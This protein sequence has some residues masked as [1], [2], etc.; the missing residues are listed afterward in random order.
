M[1]IAEFHAM[2]DEDHLPRTP[3]L[4]VDV[5]DAARTRDRVAGAD[6]RVCL[7]ALARIEAAAARDAR[8]VLGQDATPRELRSEPSTRIEP[9]TI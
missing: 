3:R 6:W 2:H 8:E 7:Y 4:L 1:L 9:R 5:V